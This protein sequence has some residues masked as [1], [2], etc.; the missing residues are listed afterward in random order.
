MIVYEGKYGTQYFPN[1]EAGVMACFHTLRENCCYECL[2]KAESVLYNRA[3]QGDYKAAW[4][5]MDSRSYYEYERV[6]VEEVEV[7][8]RILQSFG[9]DFCDYCEK[10]VPNCRSVPGCIVTSELPSKICEACD[11]TKS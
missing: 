1:T 5:L 10:W 11:A 8:E 3:M 2:D 4:S 9:I 7:A 6:C